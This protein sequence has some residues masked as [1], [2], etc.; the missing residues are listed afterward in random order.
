MNLA[1]AVLVQTAKTCN[2]NLIGDAGVAAA[3]LPGAA[4]AASLNVRANIAALDA[5]ARAAISSEVTATVAEIDSACR[6]AY[7]EVDARLCPSLGPDP[8]S[9]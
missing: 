2:P 5:E 1:A 3:I 9:V 8:T 4:H 6:S 7:S